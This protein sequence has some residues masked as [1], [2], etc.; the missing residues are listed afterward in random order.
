MLIIK[1]FL[2]NVH[3][4]IIDSDKYNIL[5]IIRMPQKAQAISMTL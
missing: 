2:L 4:R 3:N 5:Y 1:L